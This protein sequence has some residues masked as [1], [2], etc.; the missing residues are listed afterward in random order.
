MILIAG[1]WV[2]FRDNPDIGSSIDKSLESASG[3]RDACE[4][5]SAPLLDEEPDEAVRGRERIGLPGATGATGNSLWVLIREGPSGRPLDEV[6]VILLG[7][8][9][10]LES[11]TDKS[12]KVLFASL[13]AGSYEVR[14]LGEGY[15]D[16]RASAKLT[17][18]EREREIL[19]LLEPGVSLEGKVIGLSTQRPIAGVRL[20]YHDPVTG[21]DRKAESTEEGRFRLSGLPAGRSPERSNLRWG[22]SLYFSLN[23]APEILFTPLGEDR[24]ETTLYLEPGLSVSGRVLDGRGGGAAE[25][26]VLAYHGES[27]ATKSFRFFQDLGKRVLL[28]GMEVFAECSTRTDSEGYF[29]IPAVPPGI[30][31]TIA[32]IVPGH[33]RVESAPIVLDIGEA[34]SGI[35][36]RA[37]AG[38][39]ITGTVIDETDAPV[40]GALI[41]LHGRQ[42]KGIFSFGGSSQAKPKCLSVQKTDRTG[43]FAFDRLDAGEFRLRAYKQGYGN[44]LSDWFT[45]KTGEA[46]D[47]LFVIEKGALC[48]TGRIADL[49]G[50]PVPGIVVEFTPWPLPQ[51]QSITPFNTRSA[52]DGCFRVSG[53]WDGARHMVRARDP[54]RRRT[55]ERIDDL[56]RMVLPDTDGIEF[57]AYRAA[58]VSGRIEDIPPGAI[59]RVRMVRQGDDDQR[60]SRSCHA[61]NRTFSIKNLLPGNYVVEVGGRS[62]QESLPEKIVGQFCIEEGEHLEDL[63]FVY[64]KTIELKGRVLADPNRSPLKNIRVTLV[65]TALRAAGTSQNPRAGFTSETVTDGAGCFHFRGLVQGRYDLIA[66]DLRFG[67]SRLCGL[68]L[69]EG[70]EAAVLD[71]VLTQGVRVSGKAF[72]GDLDKPAGLALLRFINVEWT[73][74][75]LMTDRDGGF[76]A[77]LEPGTYRCAV[78]FPSGRIGASAIDVPPEGV[79]GLELRF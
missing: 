17:L 72:F 1:W 73:I 57:R 64:G 25:V 53:L 79:T 60:A 68:E 71:L 8:S 74:R 69:L 26:P 13:P 34:L 42:K 24:F 55:V 28:D 70:D 21:A 36:L 11:T 9:E 2:L 39:M 33:S 31:L 48:A 18:D 19:I 63:V 40:Q 30:E 51:G 66:W 5:D 12:G 15:A 54:D 20:R 44:R 29:K 45:V 41:N 35:V 32:A 43:A 49:E 10:T 78:E 58:A 76:E 61:D 65:D 67:S 50:R 22:K 37:T 77:F 62:L 59:P 4:A 47:K 14:A 27:Q 7:V 23:N 46:A 38:A 16:G 52:G 56:P 3:A 75:S 6:R